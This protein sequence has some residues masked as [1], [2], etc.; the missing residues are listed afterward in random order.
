MKRLSHSSWS[1][2]ALTVGLTVGAFGAIG[3]AAGSALLWGPSALADEPRELDPLMVILDPPVAIEDC[4]G[5][6]VIRQTEGVAR[7]NFD[8]RTYYWLEGYSHDAPHT[9]FPYPDV[10]LVISIGPG[11]RCQLH[12]NDSTGDGNALAMVLPQGLAREIT[13]DRYRREIERMGRDAFV[14]GVQDAASEMEQPRWWDEEVWALRRL[15][16]AIPEGVVTVV[17]R[18]ITSQASRRK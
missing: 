16:I 9:E 2:C 6:P 1:A 7:V 18:P 14:Q 17:P 12:W 3:A 15:D 11:D 13:L 8:G 5:S 10:E 4:I